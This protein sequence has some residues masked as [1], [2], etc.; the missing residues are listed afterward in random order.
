[1]T[2]TCDRHAQVAEDNDTEFAHSGEPLYM[3]SRFTYMYRIVHRSTLN[4]FATASVITFQSNFLCD[5]LKF[6]VK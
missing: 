3:M 6:A 2:L 1:V 5:K 4:S